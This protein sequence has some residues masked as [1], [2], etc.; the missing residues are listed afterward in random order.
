MDVRLTQPRTLKLAVVFL[1]LAAS[2]PSFLAMPFMQPVPLDF[3]NL[4]TFHDCAARDAPYAASGA[5]CGDAQLREM[6]YPPILYWAFAWTRL[7]TFEAAGQLFMV[8]VAVGTVAAVAWWL[9]R[10]AGEPRGEAADGLFAGLLLAQYPLLFAIERGNNDVVPLLLWT[11]AAHL[12]ATGRRGAAGALGGLA[13]IAKLYPAFACLV[14]AVG[15]GAQ[16]LRRPGARRG[17]AAFAAGGVLA[18]VAGFAVVWSDSVA[19]FTV[20]LPRIAALAPGLAPYAHPLRNLWEAGG[21][22]ALGAPLL[23]AW[24]AAAALVFERDAEL[25]FAGGLAISTSFAATSWDY[26]LITA[27]PLLVVLFRRML[28]PGAGWL[29]F[30]L[31]VA[32][33]IGIVGHRGLIT[34]EAG[35]RVHIAIQWA[36]LVATAAAAPWLAPPAREPGDAASPAAAAG[37]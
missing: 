7:L 23:L 26:N 32:G 9:W 35:V 3:Q 1:L 31:L 14:V 25:V 27:Y 17:F 22:W 15:A 10:G 37:A 28:R 34:T 19:Y 33:L 2:L 5:A 21:G 12:H 4:W 36:F 30:A 24:C 16:A 18:V 8:V 11:G 29:P 13:A 20:H 6:R